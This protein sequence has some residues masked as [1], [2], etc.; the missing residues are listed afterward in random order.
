M[1]FIHFWQENS[2]QNIQ[3]IFKLYNKMFI[4]TKYLFVGT[5][6]KIHNIRIIVFPEVSSYMN[7]I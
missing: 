7:L 4:G 5:I 2:L 1:E 3:S 6:I